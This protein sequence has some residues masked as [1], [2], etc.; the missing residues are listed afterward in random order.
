VN[1]VVYAW[2]ASSLLDASGTAGRLI[3]SHDLGQSWQ[4]LDRALPPTAQVNLVAARPDGRML[5]QARPVVGSAPDT[6]WESGDAG[7]SWHALGP[8]PGLT[9]TVVVTTNPADVRAGSWGVLYSV[10]SPQ[11][12]SSASA[13]M[14]TSSDGAMWSLLPSLPGAD[15]GVG[16]VE[17][18]GGGPADGL[19]V[20]RDV[21]TPRPGARVA[22]RELWWWTTR[23]GWRVASALL[24][25]NWEVDGLAWDGTQVVLWTTILAS[26]APSAVQVALYSIP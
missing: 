22:P 23:S 4:T 24:G 19:L 3:A 21:S 15:T 2:A 12:D 6:L 16:P 9:P 10:G 26:N 8:I 18:L 20:T 13:V 17:P 1:R 14:A 5:V 25:A 11:S 7:V